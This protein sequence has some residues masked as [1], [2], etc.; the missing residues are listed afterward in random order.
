[1][2][3]GG[4]FSL[5]RATTSTVELGND[6]P[7]ISADGLRIGFVSPGINQVRVYDTLVGNELTSTVGASLNPS[8]SADGTILVFAHN[9]Q[10]YMTS[11]PLASV[12]VT[13]TT[14]AVNV[15][16]EQL[17]R[18][19][20]AIRNGGPSPASNVVVTDSLGIINSTSPNGGRIVKSV[21]LTPPGAG[22]CFSNQPSTSLPITC[23]LPLLAAN[24]TVTLTMDVTPTAYGT[25]TNLATANTSTY[26]RIA[27][28]QSGITL[29]VKPLPV[30]AVDLVLS[31]PPTGTANLPNVFLANVSPITASTPLSYVWQVTNQLTPTLAY[32][33]NSFTDSQTFIW[34]PGG[35]QTVTVSVSNAANVVV[36]ATRV[37][38]I[39]NPLPTLTNMTPFTATRGGA[40]LSLNLSGTG[41]VKTSS[42]LW[43]GVPLAA[44]F[45]N[46]TTMTATVP[47]ANLTAAGFFTVAVQS[48]APGG[49]VSNPLTFTVN[50]PLPNILNTSPV[51]AI[52]GG[53]AFSLTVNG[54]NFVSGASLYWDG[55]PA[56]PTLVNGSGTVLTATIPFSYLLSTSPVA[57]TVTNP[58]PSA[59]PS[60]AISF[61]LNNPT[62]TLRV[63]PDTIGISETTTLEADIS[64]LQA[65]ARTITLTSSN[66]NSAVVPVTVT[67]P[68]G[69]PS[70]TVTVQAGS[71]GDIVNLTGQLPANIGGDIGSTSLTVNYRK[72]TIGPA[73]PPTT[74]AG[75]LSFVL[76]LAGSDFVNGA[77]LFWNGTPLAPTV[78]IN[79]SSLSATVP[80]SLIQTPGTIA[81]TV[82]NP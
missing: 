19:Q 13:K 76:T 38:T 6:Q 52:K 39:F 67:L 5:T 25:L 10:L 26:Q 59:G 36:T 37:I 35:V 75:G 49:G 47:A 27:T 45:V 71:M 21:T 46:S 63:N 23:T 31:G 48:G 60:N 8:L 62:I 43:N 16:A 12:Q 50:N 4:A 61:V 15:F 1:M 68:A 20:V 77:Q 69:S 17:V 33:R 22:T 51:S 78:V 79:G 55:L 42:V 53:L 29:T 72:P 54:S 3:G 28:N 82:V 70:V 32:T 73:S 44:G 40:T 2:D 14:T 66:T 11:Y 24:T 57:I 18:Y 7:S 41:F 30:A 80:S 74:T 58:S 9:R 64:G 34:N 65:Q 56:L 81:I